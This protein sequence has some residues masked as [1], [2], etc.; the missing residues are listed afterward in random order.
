MSLKKGTLGL[1]MHFQFILPVF[2]LAKVEE[3]NGLS[4]YKSAK[5]LFQED[6]KTVVTKLAR[7]PHAHLHMWLSSVCADFLNQ[8]ITKKNVGF[9][10]S[11]Y[12]MSMLLLYV[13]TY[14]CTLYV[15]L[16]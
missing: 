8:V 2:L 3:L 14:I 1:R 16:K 7:F 10:L 11:K 9:T 13:C 12:V 4:G 15:C 5:S 6:F